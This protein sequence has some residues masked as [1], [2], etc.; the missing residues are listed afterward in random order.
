MIAIA[1]AYNRGCNYGL[2]TIRRI[3]RTVGASPDGIWGPRT[4]ERVRAWQGAAG[5]DADGMVG[6]ATLARFEALWAGDA[7]LEGDESLDD[8]VGAPRDPDD[9]DDPIPDYLAAP[10]C[11]S[12][13]FDTNEDL[14]AGASGDAVFALQNDLFGFGFNLGPLDGQ[15][16]PA[17]V[18]AIKAFQAAAATV[19]RIRG[20]RR[21]EVEVGF[22]A[23]PS[24]VVDGATRAEIRRWKQEGY[25]WVEPGKDFFERRVRVARFGTLARSS[26]LLVEVRSSGSRTKTLHG[27]A[28]EGLAAMSAAA[29]SVGLPELA[30]ASAW[31]PHRWRSRAQYEAKMKERY[32]SV[33]EGRRWVAYSSPHETGLAIDFG[34]GGLEPRRKTAAKQRETKLYAWLKANAYRFGW[35]PY[36]LEPWHWEFPLSLRAWTTG[37]SDWRYGLDEGL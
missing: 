22:A 7:E 6:P 1:I 37:V 19:H 2:A 18:R 20:H 27:L 3:Q 4:I 23:R 16:G 14:G 30:A 35:H 11:G 36:A 5:L 9:D 33:S 15:L 25:R 10:V 28:R 31:R 24:G 21:V 17:V 34:V 12:C 32:G 13:Y 26:S 8:G 29:V